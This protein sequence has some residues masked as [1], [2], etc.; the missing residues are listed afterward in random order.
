MCP[1][2]SASVLAICTS[3][4]RAIKARHI[5]TSARLGPP[6]FGET[7]GITC[8]ILN[9]VL[10][11]CDGLQQVN[12]P[13]NHT[14]LNQSCSCGSCDFVDRSGPWANKARNQTRKYPQVTP[15]ARRA[16]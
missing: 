14:K 6:Y 7:A 10:A 1:P 12:D 16:T 5:G 4:P 8:R 11:Y 13:R 2:G 3:R 15:L 9:L